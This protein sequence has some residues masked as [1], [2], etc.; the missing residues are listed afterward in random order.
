MTSRSKIEERIEKK[1]HEIQELEMRIREARA[2]IQALQD[3]VKLMPREGASSEDAPP[4][5]DAGLRSGSYVSDARDAI[6][7]AGRPLHVVEIIKMS[8]RKNDRK[9]RTGISGS[10]AAYVRRQDTFT[11]PRPNTF[12]LL[13]LVRNV[14]PQGPPS[15]SS[16][17][18]L[19]AV[20]PQG[21]PTGPSRVEPASI[22]QPN[23]TPRRPPAN[24]GLDPR[25]DED[26][27][28]RY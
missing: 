21:P 4:D 5:S 20:S 23:L 7:K 25:D 18:D 3:V 22:T 17:F 10:L 12:G 24:F 27:P 11:R 8:G 15:H 13:E 26:Q 19:N 14:S 1:E 6:L 2:Y 9:T 16:K 28:I